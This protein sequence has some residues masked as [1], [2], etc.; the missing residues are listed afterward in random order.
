[1][2]AG[3]LSDQ[4][5]IHITHTHTHTHTHTQAFGLDDHNHSH[6]ITWKGCALIGG[7]L[8]FFVLEVLLRSLTPEDDHTHSPEHGH[9]HSPE[10]GHAHSPVSICI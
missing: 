3:T 5:R 10:H 8:A 1:M 4:R 7:M 6:E 9:A 2:R